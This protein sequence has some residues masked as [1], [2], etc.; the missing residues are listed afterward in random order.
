VGSQNWYIR[1]KA[2]SMGALF[3]STRWDSSVWLEVLKLMRS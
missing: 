3:I 1:D 2:M